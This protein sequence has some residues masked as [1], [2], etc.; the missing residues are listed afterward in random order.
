MAQWNPFEEMAALR[1]ELDQAFEN[2]GLRTGP[3]F[4]TAFLPG[5]AAREYPLCNLH[6]DRDVL[7]VEALAPGLDPAS[8]NL[9][10][11]RNTLTLSGEKQRVSGEVKPEAFHRSEREAGKFVR[12]IELPVE[13]DETKVKAEYKNGL[14]LVTLPKAEKARP[15]QINVQV[16]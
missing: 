5:R 13:V 10:I 3:T 11:V 9:T 4:R 2:F 15:R 12:T 8:V 16:I 1:R 14:V 7:Y 6:E